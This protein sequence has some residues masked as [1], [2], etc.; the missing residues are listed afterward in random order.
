MK[1]NEEQMTRYKQVV[2][3]LKKQIVS[4]VYQKGEFLPSEKELIE[5]FGVSRITIRR[6]LSMLADMGFIKTSQ[7]K[8]SEVLF[9]MEDAGESEGFSRAVEEHRQTF[10]EVEQIRLMLEPEVAK[11][12]ALTATKEQIKKLKESMKKAEE[13]Q[14]TEQFHKEL[15]A[16]L[17][18]RTLIDVME[19]LVVM[20][21]GKTPIGVVNP[22][23]QDKIRVELE[24][25]H[26]DILRAIEEKDGD[27]AYFY[28]K[29]HTMYI[30]K[31]YR[32]Y[33]EML[34]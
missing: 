14:D 3:S 6:A 12:V 20:E 27:A 23:K 19:K 24:M 30:N 25:Q 8:G 33:F 9:S 2:Y 5:S 13:E 16:V 15:F 21:G 17:G 28:M 22:E 31:M 1:K 34:K 7:G 4:G 11:V 32:E 26:K 18:N 10:T 29:K